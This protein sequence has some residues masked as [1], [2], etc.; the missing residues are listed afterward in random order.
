MNRQRSAEV[1]VRSRKIFPGG[2]NSPVRSFR[3]VGGDPIVF[4]HG[5][6]K[7]L[8]DVD[9]NTYIDFCGSWGPLI[10]GYSHPAVLSAVEKQAARALTFGAPSEEEVKLAEKI[11][12]WMPG[13]EM[14]RFV[15]S[16]TEAT[17]SAIRVARAATGRNKFVK[18]EGCY[19]GHADCLL[20]KAGSGLATLGQA[21][22]AGVPEACVQDTITG[23]YNSIEGI[24]EIFAR[25]GGEIAAV[26]VEPMAANMGL[27]LPEKGFLEALRTQCSTHGSVLIF[28]EVMTGFRVARGG[29][30]EAFAVQPDL[31]TFGKIV[32]GGLPAAAYGGK[33][34]VMEHVAP[35]GRAYQAGTLSG[36]PLAMAAGLATL[37]AME[38]CDAFNRLE[39]TGQALDALVQQHLAAAIRSG[40]VSFVRKASFFCFFFGSKQPP[41]NFTQVASTDMNLFNQVYHRW[42]DAGLYMG[43]SGY[44]V[45]FLS[46]EHTVD[47]VERLVRVVAESI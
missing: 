38:E 16:G 33:K 24:E 7:Y 39:K 47:D 13:L 4:S 28:D 5:R 42:L 26:I 32:G 21:S 23:V 29:A 1:M 10:L 18:F 35:L 3:S 30:A 2:V 43:P 12:T 9:G 34:S 17:M 20:V 31:W 45:G 44:E 8:T 15:N 25:W 27:V 37:T 46:T 11:Q 14:M 19:H 40:R 36:N 41:R 22:S 6:G